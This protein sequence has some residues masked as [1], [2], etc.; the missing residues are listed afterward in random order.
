MQVLQRGLF[1]CV[2]CVEKMDWVLFLHSTLFVSVCVEKMEK[3]EIWGQ[4]MVMR[5][6]GH[7][8]NEMRLGW[9]WRRVGQDDDEMGVG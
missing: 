8:D 1:L 3:M 9:G 6:V 7:D 4:G 5:W 2:S